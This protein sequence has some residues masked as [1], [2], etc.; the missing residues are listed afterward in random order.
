MDNIRIDIVLE[1]L[2]LNHSNQC[3][4]IF[5]IVRAIGSVHRNAN[6]V[7]REVIV[8]DHMSEK[9]YKILRYYS[10]FMQ[11]FEIGQGIFLESLLYGK[12]ESDNYKSIVCYPTRKI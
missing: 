11:E 10:E 12:W 3:A 6:K 2:E 5:C 9:I 4:Q 1:Q 8:F 7:C